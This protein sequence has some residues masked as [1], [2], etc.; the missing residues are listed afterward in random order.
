MILPKNYPSLLKQNI[1]FVSFMYTFNKENIH[2]KY[3]FT[4][5]G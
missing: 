1:S 4:K 2:L 5:R 3:K